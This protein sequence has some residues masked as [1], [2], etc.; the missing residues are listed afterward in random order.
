MGQAAPCIDSIAKG[1]AA[2]YKI[3]E[4]MERKPLIQNKENALKLG[5]VKGDIVFKD[6]E[7]TYPAK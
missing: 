6:V 1:K 7:F 3:F 4:V 5:S 2:G